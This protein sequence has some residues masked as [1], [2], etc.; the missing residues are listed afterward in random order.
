MHFISPHFHHRKHDELAQCSLRSD[1]VL[2]L[3]KVGVVYEV[4]ERTTITHVTSVD[5]SDHVN[6]T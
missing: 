5:R 1:I 4:F 3:Q 2:D 6:M